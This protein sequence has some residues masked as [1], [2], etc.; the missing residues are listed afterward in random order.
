MMNKIKIWFIEIKELINIHLGKN[1][2]KGGSPP[3]DRKVV[4]IINF[5]IGELLNIENVWLIW[6]NLKELNIKI[7]LNDKNEYIKK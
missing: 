2:I 1:P 7:N 3:N 6:Y 5:R 4:K